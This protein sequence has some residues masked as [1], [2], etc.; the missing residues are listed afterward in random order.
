[1]DRTVRQLSQTGFKILLDLFLSANDSVRFAELPYAMRPRA[2]GESKLDFQVAW[3][4]L[5]LLADKLIGRVIPVRFVMFLTI[6]AL[7]AFLH[8]AVLSVVLKLLLYS[9]AV[10]QSAA[11]LLA[12]TSNFFLNNLFTYRD[13]RLRGWR[14]VRGLTSFYLICS[15]GA[16]VNVVVATFL[17]DGGI[18]WWASGLLGAVVGAVWNFA[19]TLTFT[20]RRP[21]AGTGT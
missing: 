17:Y 20:W 15:A 1:M 19:V 12:M 8:L 14:M 6:G 3:E 10:G 11:T 5:V 21:S 18:P 2:R 4:F 9:F 16:F 7:G 13:V